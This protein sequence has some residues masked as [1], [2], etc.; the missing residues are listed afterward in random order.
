MARFKPIDMSPRFLAV[1][2]HSQVLPGTFEYALCHLID[3]ELDLSELEARFSNDDCGAPAYAPS[4]LLKIVLLAYSRGII[5]SRAMQRACLQNVLFMAISGDTQPDH[6]T[7]AA[8]VSGMGDTVAKFFA[9]VLVVCDRQGLIGREL[10]AIDGVKLPSNAAKARSGTRE[11][12]AEE[13]AKMEAAV[14]KMIERQQIA[15]AAGQSAEALEAERESRTIE[16]LRREAEH[17][18][19]WLTQH[20]ED[21]RGPTDGLRKSNRTDNES[22]KMATSKGVIQGYTGVATVDER[23]QIVVD[24][25]A[26]GTGSEQELLLPVVDAIK[27]MLGK[28]TAIVA[29]AGYHSEDNLQGLSERGVDA[30]IA[31]PQMR[32]RDERFADQSKHKS[33]PDP[34]HD[35]AAQPAKP[36]TRFKPADFAFD[37]ATRCCICPAGKKLYGNGSECTINGYRAMKFQGAKQDC[38]PC[39]LRGQ[40]LRTPEKTITRQVSFFLGRRD[41]GKNWIAQMKTRIDSPAG[42]QRIG[43]RFATVEPV[44]GNL[45]AN[46]RLDR[47][48]LRGKQKVDGQWKLYCMVHNIEKLAHHGYAA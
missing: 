4:V 34:L 6:S 38:Q 46:K 36:G 45:R 21:R 30:W 28:N 10:F 37:E 5:S 20:P 31:D 29:D 33:K 25:Q 42:R 2:L 41:S 13:A 23:H 47:F 24:A 44:F 40:C 1:D 11:E 3:H 19:T 7:L 15:D 22:A 39:S 27:P 32:Q 17:I 43:Q 9:R 18:R 14:T 16:R 8:F 35:K 48:T 26:H 12:F